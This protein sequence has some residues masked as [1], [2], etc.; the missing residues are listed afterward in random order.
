MHYWAGR[1]TPLGLGHVTMLEAE[2]RVEWDRS[3][4]WVISDLW[5]KIYS[6]QEYEEF[7]PMI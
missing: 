5:E 1:N 3:L 6:E 2:R 7:D 4:K